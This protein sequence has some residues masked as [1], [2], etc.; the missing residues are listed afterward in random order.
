MMLAPAVML[1]HFTRLLYHGRPAEHEAPV[2]AAR[3]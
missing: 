3:D 2:A 1:A